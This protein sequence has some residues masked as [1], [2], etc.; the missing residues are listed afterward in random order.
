[1]YNYLGYKLMS[2]PYNMSQTA[3]GWIFIIY[4]FGTF[5]S[6]WMGKLSDKIGVTVV[7]V[8]GISIMFI[9]ALLTL[10]TSFIIKIVRLILVTF[11]LFG[12]HSIASNW[13]G[14]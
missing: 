6:T 4:L 8:L 11:G 10:F 14:K 7:L 12:S 3:V 9:G 5:S 2:P 1:M 13:V